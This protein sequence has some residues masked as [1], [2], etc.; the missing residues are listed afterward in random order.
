[1]KKSKYSLDLTQGPIGRML[2][3][4]FLPIAAGNLFQQLYNTADALIIAKF[5]G[6][7]ALASVGG[8]PSQVINVIIGVFSAL[9]AG[10]SVVISQAYGSGDDERMSGAAN[11]SV[12]MSVLF[13]IAAGV[14]GY[15]YTPQM[16]LSMKTP[17]DTL[18]GAVQ[19]LR[20]YFGGM[21]F[22]MLYNMGSGI[23]R[24][25]GDSKRPLYALIVCCM[26]NIVL[27]I[28]FVAL[29]GLGIAGVA[30]A[31][32][33]SQLFSAVIVMFFLY[34]SQEAYRVAP[35]TLCLKGSSL[36]RILRIGIPSALQ[37]SMYSVSNL[38]IQVAVNSLGTVI[39]ASWTMTGKID[40]VYW[41][42]S[43]ALGAA[44]MSFSGQN[45]GAGLRDRIRSCAR[46][47]MLLSAGITLALEALILLFGK[48]GTQL[49]IDDAEV[50]EWT[51]RIL[52]YFVPYYILWTAIEVLSG[53][54]RG[55]GDTLVP[56]IL[57]AVGICGVRLVWI[58]T[59]F[60]T[61]H[62]A[63][64]LS[65]SYAASWAITSLAIY[66]YYEIKRRRVLCEP[67]NT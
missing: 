54:L 16:L 59:V 56:V 41:A 7:E 44:I 58:A 67:V 49:L 13:G 26:T 43:S 9:S 63:K 18:D 53:V 5:V 25:V 11:T 51:N 48:Y 1:M 2:L 39:V 34:R 30:W 60:Q 10:A 37:S 38:I 55:M 17:A 14:L 23:L 45:Y 3:R 4:F 24:A 40:G 50:I 12:V 8:S 64:G 66:V 29:F 31:T 46:L 47:G 61:Y 27:D 20:I 36:R 32:V 19:Y 62:T 6:R 21:A 22:N 28:A 57:T 15:I 65:L 42:V 33:L 52:T 35:G